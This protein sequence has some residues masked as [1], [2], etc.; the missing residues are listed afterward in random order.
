ML[1]E[2][3]ISGCWC[4]GQGRFY[5]RKSWESDNDLPSDGRSFYKA[6]AVPAIHNLWKTSWRCTRPCHIGVCV[7]VCVPSPAVLFAVIPGTLMLFDIIPCGALFRPSL[8]PG[9]AAQRLGQA[10]DC[11]PPQWWEWGACLPP[12]TPNPAPWNTGLYSSYPIW[13]PGNREQ[14]E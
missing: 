11:S 1:C 8:A 6:I 2:I 7:C 4:L 14:A 12:I 9:G 13:T 3:S 5:K 10:C